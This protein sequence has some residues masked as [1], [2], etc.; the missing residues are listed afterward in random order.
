[1]ELHASNVGKT[2]YNVLATHVLPLKKISTR[3]STENVRLPAMVD[4]W[5]RLGLVE[6]DYQKWLT[7]DSAYAWVE[8][9]PEFERLRAT[10]ESETRKVT[11]QRGLLIRTQFGLQFAAAVGLI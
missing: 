4:N 11:Y 3:N 9:R 6:V 1:M 7:D 8:Q 5:I 10:H 2:G